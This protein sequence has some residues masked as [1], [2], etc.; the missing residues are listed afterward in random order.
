[1]AYKRRAYSNYYNKGSSSLKRRTYGQFKAARKGNDSLSFVINSNYC[2]SAKY[3]SEGEVGTACV[4]I[5]EVLCRNSNFNSMKN[6]YDQVRLDG[7]RVKLA[8][9]DAKTSLGTV[10]LIKNAAIYT[11]WDRTGLGYNQV[12]LY[13]RDDNDVQVLA[14][15]SGDDITAWR[16]KIGRGIVNATGVKKSI[17]N[18]FQRWNSYSSCYPSLSN[19]KGQYIST[20]DIE[21]FNQLTNYDTTVTPVLD[22]YQFSFDDLKNNSNPVIPFESSVVKFKPCLLVGVF[23]NGFDAGNIITDYGNA[24]AV[25]FNGEFTISVTFKNLKASR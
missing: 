1:M 4:N 15:D 11:A 12:Q 3:N 10:N 5:W 9:T 14:N 2:F 19:E 24:D 22:Q 16:T 23:T 25:L 7:V 17:L 18:T 21:E 6:M 13:T 20:G 8:V